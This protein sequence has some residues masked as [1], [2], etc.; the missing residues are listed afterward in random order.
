VRAVHRDEDADS[1]A[2]ENPESFVEQ[3]VKH[4][5]DVDGAAK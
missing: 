1:G 2:E 4:V 3:V 5:L